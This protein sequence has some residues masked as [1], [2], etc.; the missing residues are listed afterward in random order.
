MDILQG[1]SIRPAVP[2]DKK[3]VLKFCEHTWEWGDYIPQVWDNWLSDPRGRLL[4][5][6]IGD[7]LVAMAQ[8]TLV[9]PEEAWLQGLRVAPSHRRE[10][11]ATALTRRCIEVATELGARVARGAT[12]ATNVSTRIAAR[13]GLHQVASFVPCRADAV[14]GPLQL[15][16]PDPQALE[17]LLTFAEESNLHKATSG[18]YSTGWTYQKLTLD[19][20]RNHLQKG[21]VFTLGKGGE[22]RALAITSKGF[23]GQS[24]I[25][26]YVNGSPDA[27]KKLAFGLRVQA[28]ENTP[29]QIIAQ[30]PD[31]PSIRSIFSSTGYTPLFEEPFLVFE[32][33]LERSSPA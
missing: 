23:P 5:G 30:L 19:K 6:T 9:A 24:M 32:L 28:A 17:A 27:L 2:E 3:C 18:L 15:S 33:N 26:G 7:Q 14:E 10:N 20:L 22:V 11:I 31:L 12:L 21:E 29:P 4:V 25:A 13:L 8:V 1:F 16:M